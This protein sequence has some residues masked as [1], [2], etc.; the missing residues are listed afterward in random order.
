MALKKRHLTLAVLA[1][2]STLVGVNLDL[3]GVDD[4]RT[5]LALADAST[6][7]KRLL[8]G[9]PMRRGIALGHGGNPKGQAVD[10]PIGNAG[11]AERDIRCGAAIP[12][13]R[14]S[15]GA[16]LD[17][18][19]HPIGDFLLDVG[20]LYGAPTPSVL[21]SFEESNQDPN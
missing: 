20:S 14:P 1:A 4:G 10:A 19:E 7:R 9:Q 18:R 8:E 15:P 13:F 16:G 17:P 6:K 12:R 21:R 5:L 11:R 2:L 3:V